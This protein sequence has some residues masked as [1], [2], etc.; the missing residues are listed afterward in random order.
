[1][2]EFF[3]VNSE[4][5]TL[6]GEPKIRDVEGDVS[7]ITGGMRSATLANTTTENESGVVNWR[8]LNENEENVNNPN[9]VYQG[10]SGIARAYQDEPPLNS[11]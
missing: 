1:M 3:K 2:I 11:E 5:A 8:G 7:L 4:F 9:V 6:A 10:R